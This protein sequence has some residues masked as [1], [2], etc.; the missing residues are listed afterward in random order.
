MSELKYYHFTVENSK[1]EM[2]ASIDEDKIVTVIGY[3]NG[4]RNESS[5]GYNERK[6]SGYEKEC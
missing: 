3:F 5:H 1:T 4:F 2:I 6:T